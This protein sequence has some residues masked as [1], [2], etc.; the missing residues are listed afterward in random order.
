MHN[1]DFIPLA[2]PSIDEET[3]EEVAKVLRSGWLTTGSI[4]ERFERALADYMG[5]P[6]AMTVT[7]GT[8]GIHLAIMAAGIEPGSEIITT[9]FTFVATANAI[10]HAGCVPVFADIDL[11]TLNI[12]PKAIEDKITSK[13]KAIIPVHYAGVPV[14]M[15]AVYKIAASH[16]LR[17]I[18]DSAHA[19][20]TSYKGKKI[21]SFG[22]IQVF[23]FHPIKNIT[24][25][26]GGCVVFRN[27]QEA[28]LFAQIRF[29][30][31]NRSI[32]DRF[33]K[34]S[35]RLDYD[36]V[37]PGYK[38]N[39]S[40][41]QSVIGLYQLKR[42]DEMNDRRREISAKYS[43]AFEGWDKVFVPDKALYD[44]TRSGHLFPVLLDLKKISLSRDE[45]IARLKKH[46]IGSIAYY[47]PV[48][49]F[50]YYREKFGYKLNDFPEAEDAGCR[51][52]CLP[53]Y[54]D[55]TE[56]QQDLVIDTFKKILEE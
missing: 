10:V 30:G 37:C 8:A 11:N 32:W 14:D 18:E 39:M 29:H 53:V 2:I 34:Q 41:I 19:F 36:V 55:M 56:D 12:S 33:K 38:L 40:D 24:T 6:L 44:F 1:E 4:N 52:I 22:D 43:S 21:G 23:S 3:I 25:G 5:A 46:N 42:V 17:V 9:P 54:P 47:Y 45:V 16:N 20:G 48:H 49:L 7:S 28:D 51:V 35:G 15:D 50:T 13:T 31:I 26:E 27:E